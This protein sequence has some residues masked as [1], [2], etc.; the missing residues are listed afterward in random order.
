MKEGGD[1]HLS[2]WAWDAKKHHPFLKVSADASLMSWSSGTH[3]GLARSST[4]LLHKKTFVEIAKAKGVSQ[5]LHLGLAKTTVDFSCSPAKLQFNQVNISGE[6]CAVW[7]KSS[8]TGDRLGA[9]IDLDAHKLTVYRN[10]VEAYHCEIPSTFQVTEDPNTAPSTA[11]T[12]STE[13]TEPPTPAMPSDATAIYPFIGV[14]GDQEL[15]VT[16][17]PEFEKYLDIVWAHSRRNQLKPKEA[18]ALDVPGILQ[19]LGLQQLRPKFEGMSL[20]DFQKLKDVDL[21]K[22]GANPDQR[23]RLLSHLEAK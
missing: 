22:I 6:W 12:S 1:V 4:P 3:Y 16:E 15:I 19:S 7:I 10:G 11:A 20:A 8:S 18:E 23:K 13:L 14:C 9:L 21:R 5:H 2:H 17:L